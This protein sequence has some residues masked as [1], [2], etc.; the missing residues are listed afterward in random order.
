MLIQRRHFIA[1][2]F[3]VFLLGAIAAYYFLPIKPS[4]LELEP[5]RVSLYHNEQPNNLRPLGETEHIAFQYIGALYDIP[6]KHLGV[7]WQGRI[8]VPDDNGIVI[9][10][11]SPDKA[12]LQIDGKTIPLNNHTH[13]HVAL[14]QGE[15]DVAVRYEPNWHAG[16]LVLNFFPFDAEP[17][18]AASVAEHLDTDE[19]D[20]VVFV[21]ADTPAINIENISKQRYNHQPESKIELLGRG[22]KQIVV[23]SSDRMQNIQLVPLRGAVI[24]AVVALNNIGHVRGTDA[25]I[26]RVAQE[27][28]EDWW[29]SNCDCIGGT[30]LHCSTETG[31]HSDIQQL[32]Q[33]LTGKQTD[34]WYHPE[35][36]WQTA[37]KIQQLQQ[38]AL[39]A[40]RDAQSRC[41]GPDSP[42]FSNNA[43]TAQGSEQS[44]F[45]QIGGTLPPTGF[46]AYYFNQNQ[47]NQVVATENVP[48]IGINYVANQF[49]NIPSE[50]FAALWAGHLKLENDTL[51]AMQY[52]ISWA[53]MRVFLN[54]Q[55]VFEYR[56]GENGTPQKD[57]FDLLIPKGQ[58]RLEVE[59]INHWH[60]VGF[61]LHPQPK[62]T[63][64]QEDEIQNLLNNPAYAVVHAKVYESK[65]RDNRLP[66]YLPPERHKPMIL[67]LESHRSV[68]WQ[69]QA[70]GQ[71]LQA[72]IIED[73][74]GVV[75]GQNRTP[76]YRVPQLPRPQKPAWYF[77]DYNPERIDVYQYHSENQDTNQ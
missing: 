6:E 52:D 65:T 38:T 67:I 48:H 39:Q 15:Y 54:G 17:R 4:S 29:P 69:I 2:L 46:V 25:P 66:I 32:S 22:G 40:Q 30:H 18:L 24:K 50:S 26:Y 3:A 75:S 12:Q 42:T 74:K 36:K 57:S 7:L 21:Q 11:N 68:F 10:T 61:S 51:M 45:S 47:M 35:I 9:Q 73:G 37:S 53:Q 71:A 28:D 27:I 41:G 23:L 49:H 55:K 70:S 77:N 63:Q 31:S 64:S 72:V 56:H 8:R 13:T 1:L 5:Y 44:W 14:T 76:V 33:T 43:P 58:H 59:Y 19:S 62:I 20:V 60:T 16:E 34:F